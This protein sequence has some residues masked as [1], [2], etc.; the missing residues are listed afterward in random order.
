MT[1]H[2]MKPKSTAVTKGRVCGVAMLLVMGF[3]P[4]FNVPQKPTTTPTR[5]MDNKDHAE[6]ILIPGG[7]F[8][9]GMSQQA[10]K[11]LLKGN[12]LGW[13]E[14]YA[15][16][17][18]RQQ[19]EVP[20]FYIDRYEV[21]NAQY[22]QFMKETGHR[23]PKY[24]SRQLLNGPRQP[25]VGV[26]WADAEA[27]AQWAGERLPTEE[28]WEKAARG[29]DGRP[30]PWGNTPDNAAYNGRAQGRGAPVD[31]GSFPAGDSP[32]GVSDMAGNVWE[33]TSGNYDGHSKTMR[34]GSFLNPLGDVRVTVRWSAEDEDRGAVWLGLRCAMDAASW[35]KFATSK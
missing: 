7:R 28:E 4:P 25:V 2:A 1:G 18:P 22:A 19:K 3:A 11:A 23:A 33:M 5:I 10:I 35:S 29:T 16:E 12:K 14:I 26:G 6:M 31:V 13:A 27:Y 34:G 17:L 24:W 9:Y 32:Y 8:E 21:T 15:F 20:A 30:W